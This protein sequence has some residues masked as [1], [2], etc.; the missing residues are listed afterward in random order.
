M[1]H[2]RFKSILTIACSMFLG[3]AAALSQDFQ[4][5]YYFG[6]QPP[7]NPDAG[8]VMGPDGNFYGST[9]FGGA[10]NQ[11]AIYRL[12]PTGMLT[13]IVDF[14]G[15]NGAY[16]YASLAA[17][18]NGN[19]YGTTKNGG[20][21][22]GVVFRVTTNGTLTVLQTLNTTIGANPEGT[23]IWGNDGALYGTTVGGGAYGDGA[24]F[25]MT[26]N[27]VYT[28][29]FSFAST[30]GQGPV[31]GLFLAGDGNFYG[32]TQYGGPNGFGTVFRLTPSGTQTI[33]G[34]FDFVNNGLFPTA[35]LVEDSVGNLYGT[36][37]LGGGGG[38]GTGALFEVP[39][40]NQN[41]ILGIGTFQST[42]SSGM[43][44]A[45]SGIFY[46]ITSGS[47][48][49][50]NAQTKVMTNIYQFSSTNASGGVASPFLDT[51]G[52]IY[53]TTFS[54]G[55]NGY[56]TVFKLD[57]QDHF[58]EL[59][60]FLASPGAQPLCGLVQDSN[61]VLYGTTSSGGAANAGTIFSLQTN[62][63]F[64]VLLEFES[65]NGALPEAGMILNAGTLYGTTRFGGN[66]GLSAGE[67][68]SIS[69]TGTNFQ[70]PGVFNETQVAYPQGSVVRDAG[71]NLYGTGVNG[72]AYNYGAVFK[73][74]TNGNVTTLASFNETNGENP[75]C[76]LVLDGTN[77]W[78]TTAG[79][80][81]GGYGTVFKISTNGIPSNTFLAP[82]ATFK[83]NNGS[84]PQ[85]GLTFGPDGALYGVAEASGAYDLGCVYRV[86]SDGTISNLVS[87][88]G[89]NGAF[90]VGSLILGTNGMFYGTTAGSGIG[91]I[92]SNG[93]V[94]S[95]TTNG[96]LTTFFTFDGTNGASPSGPLIFGND[97]A[98]YGTTKGGSGIA[99]GGTVFR[100]VPSL[101]SPIPLNI[102][103]V[104][105]GVQ[106]SWSD[107]AFVLQSS[108]QP[109]GPFSDVANVVSPY[110][111]TATGKAVFYRLRSKP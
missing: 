7:N 66:N 5:L 24:A 105:G 9:Y 73:V 8:V 108:S 14:N 51:G 57:T 44:P 91:Q 94:F 28:N 42:S 84:I 67:V 65:T 29:F 45:G 23:L 38:A 106:V 2:Q 22:Y 90:P 39:A 19:F 69:T 109:N 32:T 99:A 25:R 37:T 40:T 58:T 68:F 46:G 111:T 55:A 89:A 107:P 4:T 77:L 103:M 49:Q 81:P 85:A 63:T 13:N 75:E 21:G 33:L 80:G 34:S 6:A 27:G 31:A 78:G 79:G 101:I 64:K 18:G 36:S 104:N 98:L 20:N 61:G 97:G 70:T 82:F 35:S 48:Y 50:F 53:G 87:F 76:T 16:P 88:T 102:Q 72:G 96:I 92:V 1:I 71:G 54:G 47:V 3:S 95:V 60:S 17:D 52:N 30:N 43:V 93:T 26:T 41:V 56:G 59:Y 10:Y 15:I 12:T 83:G 74:D 110:L 86:D 62:G 100:L 11:G